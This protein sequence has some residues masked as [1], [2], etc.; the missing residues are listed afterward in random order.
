MEHKEEALKQ[1]VSRLLGDCSGVEI[2]F[3]DH[4]DD[5]NAVALAP[6]GDP[7][8]LIYISVEPDET[9]RY[10]FECEEPAGPGLTDYKIAKRQ[11]GCSYEELLEAART[12]LKPS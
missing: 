3:V 8:R 9:G 1:V 6:K 11:S 2:D 5:P 12:H 10:Y 7:R 4:W